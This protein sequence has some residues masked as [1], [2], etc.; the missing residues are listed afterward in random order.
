MVCYTIILF[1]SFHKLTTS[2][3]HHKILCHVKMKTKS[4]TKLYKKNQNSNIAAMTFTLLKLKEETP[5]S[6]GK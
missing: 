4:L 5:Y 2:F 1:L 3:K 6:K